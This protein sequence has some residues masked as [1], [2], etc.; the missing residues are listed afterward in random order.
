MSRGVF[1]VFTQCT[2]A[3]RE[4]EFN[5]WYTHTHLP[6]L[7]KAK[8]FVGARRFVSRGAEGQ[9]APY[10]VI[11]EFENDDLAESVEDLI[12]RAV[13]A[14]AAGRHIDCI[15][16]AEAG[17][18]FLFEE[19]DPASLAPLDRLDYPTEMPERIRR[20]VEALLGS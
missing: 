19:I 8:G 14:F 20:G 9:P 13:A 3:A 15:T 5:R 12:R 1:L 17:S 16:S 18:S 10:L 11:Y 6:D 4:E 2:D 7:S